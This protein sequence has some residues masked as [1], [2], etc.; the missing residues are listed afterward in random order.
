MYLQFRAKR[1]NDGS[2]V[3][4]QKIS[5]SDFFFLVEHNMLTGIEQFNGEEYVPVE[6]NPENILSADCPV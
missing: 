6:L 2:R 1:K 5:L 3:C 4:T